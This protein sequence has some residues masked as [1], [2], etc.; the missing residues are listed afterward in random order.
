MHNHPALSAIL[1]VLL[2][3]LLITPVLSNPIP[4]GDLSGPITLCLRSGCFDHLC[5]SY[6]KL[7]TRQKRVFNPS[8]S[9]C[10]WKEEYRCFDLAECVWKPSLGR[11]GWSA[12]GDRDFDGCVAGLNSESSSLTVGFR[13]RMES[14]AMMSRTAPLIVPTATS[15]RSAPLV[16]P[17]AT[18]GVPQQT[19]TRAAAPFAALSSYD[20]PIN[21][22]AS[23]AS[24]SFAPEIAATSMQFNLATEPLPIIAF[25]TVSAVT[26]AAPS[27]AG[28]ASTDF[29]LPMTT[30]ASTPEPPV[31][32]LP[33]RTR[34][35][36]AVI[37]TIPA[38]DGPASTLSVNLGLMGPP[39]AEFEVP[40]STTPPIA[41]PTSD[42]PMPMQM[43]M[44]HMRV[45][46]QSLNPP[47][48][49][50]ESSEVSVPMTEMET[51]TDE[52]PSLSW[53]TPH[54]R[55]RRQYKV[56]N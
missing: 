22:L 34:G 27:A 20:A 45:R 17:S 15:Q 26:V 54:L 9:S 4:Q 25:E 50:Q 29:P 16:L 5:I 37:A 12:S 47:S 30:F 19:A 23:E 46:R 3:L 2:T 1:Y 39:V 41:A 52:V 49:T 6:R 11:C 8:E 48:L 33:V 38:K 18:T 42:L 43:P 24:S 55:G 44:S 40:A 10:I 56:L 7:D 21:T 53:P 35:A 13:T 14:E 36:V 28:M 31:N 51:T 32:V